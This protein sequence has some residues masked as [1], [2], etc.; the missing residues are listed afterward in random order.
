M[1]RTNNRHIGTYL[2][3]NSLSFINVL[4]KTLSKSAKLG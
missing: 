4:K 1:P 3:L 2:R